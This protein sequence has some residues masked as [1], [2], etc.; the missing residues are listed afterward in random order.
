MNYPVICLFEEKTNYK[1][2]I[3]PQ[4]NSLMDYA[5][6]QR[7]SDE[8]KLDLGMQIFSSTMPKNIQKENIPS[9]LTLNNVDVLTLTVPTLEKGLEKFECFTL[10]SPN[11]Y[12]CYYV[13]NEKSLP[14]MEKRDWDIVNEFVNISRDETPV[15]KKSLKLH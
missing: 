1:V 13:M 9:D 3:F 10:M 12:D 7:V 6:N 14:A 11:D 4:I 2:F 8:D 15:V 5:R